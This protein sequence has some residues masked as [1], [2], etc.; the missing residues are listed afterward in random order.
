[1]LT[2]PSPV[3]VPAH[4]QHWVDRVSALAATFAATVADDDRDARLPVEHLRALS[5]TGWTRPSSPSSTEGRGSR[6]RRSGRSSVCSRRSIPPSRRSGSCTRGPRT[7][8]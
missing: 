3:A 4:E 6:T 1:M 8:S 7:P 2:R 5:A